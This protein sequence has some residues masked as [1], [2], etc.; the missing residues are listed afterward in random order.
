MT[1]GDVHRFADG[2]KWLETDQGPLLRTTCMD[3]GGPATACLQYLANARC[4]GCSRRFH[5]LDRPRSSLPA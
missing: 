4:S 2:T 3:C 5:G 1:A